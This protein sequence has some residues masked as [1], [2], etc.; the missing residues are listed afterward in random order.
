MLGSTRVPTL[1]L[2][3][4]ESFSSEFEFQQ[5]QGGR[6]RG[7][8]AVLVVITLVVFLG[9]A[10][11]TVDVGT[12]YNA[13][14]DLQRTA[15]AA[16]LAAASRLGEQTLGDPLALARATAREF[17]GY[18]GVFDR[19]LDLD[20]SDI[21]FGRGNYDPVAHTLTFVPTTTAPNAVRVNV[22]MA[23]DSP[24]G[25]LGLYF[26][27][28]FGKYN[29]DVSA[30][31]TAMMIPRD[32][33]IV[34]DLSSSHTDDS[35]FRNYKNTEIKMWEPWN[36]LPGGYGEIGSPWVSADIQPGWVEPDG[37]VPQAAGPAWGY[38]K[39]IGY[40]DM[41][42]PTTY[43]PLTDPGLVR[44][45]YGS[46]WSNAQL[47]SYLSA[48]G[49]NATEVSAIMNNGAGD[50]STSYPLR[51]AT[52]L[53]LA[54][55]N[56]GIAGGRWSTVGASPG[57]GNNNI[58]SSEVQWT[59][60]IMGRSVSASA[61]I[62][63]SY[64][65]YTRASNNVMTQANTN[66]RY[67][68]GIKTFISY[69]LD[70]REQHSMTPEFGN[71]PHYPMQPIK[72]ATQVLTEYLYELDSN[73]QVSLEVFATTA[74]HEVDLT[75][76]FHEVSDRLNAMHAGYYDSNTFT[77]GGLQ[78]GIDE[79]TGARA[80]SSA[81]KVMVLLSDGLAN[82]TSPSNCSTSDANTL[83]EARAEA[84][85]VAQDASDLGIRIFTVA[86]GSAAD[87]GLM[88]DIAETTGAET[89]VAQG[90][91]DEYA[92]ELRNIFITIGGRRPVALVE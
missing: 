12:M 36:G 87:P 26:S 18:N 42:V 28:I 61:S 7:A 46:N 5:S 73:D 76:N 23:A 81:K 86:V 11:L 59:Q 30:M 69:L 65:N 3:A 32:V 2:R 52:A 44:L 10:A 33:A 9:C 70:A 66:L 72:D 74:H 53:G 34:A 8:V 21:T 20:T 48:Q 43:N 92:Q 63:Q 85:A 16:A 68:Y 60:Q 78:A 17:T 49:Y 27:A 50:S 64:I 56:S 41:I 58:V 75:S 47:S 88:A 83:A 91:I 90:S 22:R 1:G 62:F 35:E 24:N 45:V 55:W 80:R 89:F 37:S 29:T 14:S 19:S 39:R 25:P 31:A 38:M 84:L 40:G 79:L 4:Q 71:A 54:N 15:D 57:N 67:S 13:R 77:A 82:C 6:R 51:V